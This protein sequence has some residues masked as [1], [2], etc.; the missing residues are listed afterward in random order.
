MQFPSEA[1]PVKSKYKEIEERLRIMIQ[2]EDPSILRS[3]NGF[4]GKNINNPSIE[5]IRLQFWPTNPASTRTMRY[6]SQFNIKYQI[7]ARKLRKDH[8]DAHYDK[9]KVP[10]GEDTVFQP[11]NAIRHAI[12]FFNAIQTHYISTMP[13]IL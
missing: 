13:P 10:I 12:E 11:S 6:T 1:S 7:Q 4:K 2:L 5:W 3:N 8:P 9:H